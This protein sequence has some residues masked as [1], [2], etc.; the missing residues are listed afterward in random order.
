[1]RAFSTS[2][3]QSEGAPSYV[4]VPPGSS[5][6]DPAYFSKPEA[7]TKKVENVVEEKE[8]HHMSPVQKLTPS[9]KAAMLKLNTKRAPLAPQGGEHYLPSGC[10]ISD[11]H[12]SIKDP[13]YYVDAEK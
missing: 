4:Y 7:T 5:V 9:H 2:L 3:R 1:M 8:S 12:Y 13:V 11:P 10:S 6:S